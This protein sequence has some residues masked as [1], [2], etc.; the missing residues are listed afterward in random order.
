M[1]IIMG[2]STGEIIWFEPISQKYTRLNKNV[3][4]ISKQL[5]S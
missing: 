3:C 2:F 1:D 5:A 4:N